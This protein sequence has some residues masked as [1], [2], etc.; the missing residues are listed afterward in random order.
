MDRQ[1]HESATVPRTWLGLPL[2]MLSVNC[3]MKPFESTSFHTCIIHID[4]LS[5]SCSAGKAARAAATSKVDA[6]VEI[7]IHT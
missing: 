1:T 4:L 6:I 2:R 3:S 7:A 5:S